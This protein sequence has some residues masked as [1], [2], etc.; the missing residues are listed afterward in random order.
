MSAFAAVAVVALVG[1]SCT[2]PPVGPA[3]LAIAYINVD[4]QDGYDPDTDILIAQFEDADDS[5]DPTVGDVIRT[6]QYPR[7]LTAADISTFQTTEHTIIDTGTVEYTSDKVIVGAS[8][9]QAETDTG[10]GQFFGWVSEVDGEGEAYTEFGNG[11]V[12][13]ILD[14][15]VDGGNDTIL[16]DPDNPSQSQPDTPT[17]QTTP[18]PGDQPFIDVDV[19]FTPPAP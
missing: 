2:M 3:L 4:G 10:T 18:W 16:A 17:F 5:G 7:L 15:I 12:S 14:K 19:F 6:N 8:P 13:Q 9:V 1:V 11:G